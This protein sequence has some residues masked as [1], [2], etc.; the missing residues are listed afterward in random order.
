M[1]FHISCEPPIYSTHMPSIRN[2]CGFLVDNMLGSCPL[3]QPM[4][5]L[6]VYSLNTLVVSWPY[7]CGDTDNISCFTGIPIHSHRNAPSHLWVARVHPY[8]S[9][10]YPA[11]VEGHD[12]SYLRLYD[13]IFRCSLGR[14]SA[15]YLGLTLHMHLSFTMYLIHKQKRNMQIT[16]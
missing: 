4:I 11:A 6:N 2:L 15:I 16:G 7:P 8:S 10:S 5:H 12:K 9:D 14:F 1:P 3:P 13:P